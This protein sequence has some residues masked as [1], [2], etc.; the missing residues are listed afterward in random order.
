MLRLAFLAAAC[1]APVIAQIPYGHL[2][3]AHRAAS[4]TIPAIQI[5]DPATLAVTP[6][7]P[8]TGALSNHGG[9]TIAIDP[10]APNVIYSAQSLAI[11]LATAI[12][13]L[14]LTGNTFTRATL[15]VPLGSGGLVHRMRF[16]PGHGLLLMGRGGTLNRTFLRNM[17][18]GTITPQPTATLLP[19]NASDLAFSSG[20]AYASSEG[21]GTTITQGAI[22][23]W[24]LT[25][26]TD[27]L[28]G[29]TYPPITAIAPFGTQLLAGDTTGNLHLIDP[30]TGNIALFMPTG[31][32]RINSLAVDPQSR[33]FV[34][35]ETATNWTIWAFPS[36]TTPLYTA[37]TAIDDLKTGPGQVPTMLTYGAGC[38]GSNSM[39]PAFVVTAM[40]GLGT[41]FP[42]DLGGGLPSGLCALVLGSSRVMDGSGPLPRSLSFMGMNGCTQYTDVAVAL[43]TL[44]STSGN[45]SMTVGIPSNP[46]L[47]GLQVPM[48]WL[49][50]DQAANAF[51]ATTSN[52]G[53]AHLR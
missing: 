22:V 43:F 42:I 24:D 18:T 11:S 5:I 44:I 45:A 26:N 13:V 6:L 41:S 33:I 14:T 23:E 38:A 20:K 32:G 19:N 10:A 46:A 12:N 3:F 48:Q 47:A 16:A 34:L 51:G 25:A 40:P 36:F 1:T 15:N 27:R 52:G 8:S 2:V 21:N 9:R 4:T 39:T 37:T 17:T 7:L 31:L 30:V 29:S 28:V 50:L 49:C 35:V 53:E